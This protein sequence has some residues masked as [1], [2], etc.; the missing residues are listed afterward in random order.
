MA[1]I[2]L[3]LMDKV[4]A[5]KKPDS[6]VIRLDRNQPHTKI[7]LDEYLAKVVTSDR[8]RTGKALLEQNAALLGEIEAKYGV[9]K[10]FVVALWGLE[11]GY[12]TNTGNFSVVN[13]LM[14]LAYDGRRREL[15]EKQLL[16]ALKIIQNGHTTDAEMIGSWAGAMGQC[17]FMPTS[18]F[19]YAVDYNGDGKRD[20][21]NTKADVFASISNYLATVGWGK[22]REIKEKA[23]LDWNKSDYFVASVFKLAMGIGYGDKD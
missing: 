11:T 19:M 7:T 6:T 17:Q 2:D 10:E 12:G 22:E 3:A 23:L 13:S 14:T 1:G 18:F 16:N 9:N 8:I 4:F 21:W 15:F 5:G 20:I